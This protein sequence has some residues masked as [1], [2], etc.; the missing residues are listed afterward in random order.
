MPEWIGPSPKYRAF[1]TSQG[2]PALPRSEK[3]K[4]LT[5]YKQQPMYFQQQRGVCRA[6]CTFWLQTALAGQSNYLVD[7]LRTEGS[8]FKSFNQEGTAVKSY[9]IKAPAGDS[10]AAALLQEQLFAKSGGSRP[11][12]EQRAAMSWGK[13]APGTLYKCAPPVTGLDQM[14]MPKTI[15]QFGRAYY[16]TLATLAQDRTADAENPLYGGSYTHHA[17]ATVCLSQIFGLFDPNVGNFFVAPGDALELT[18]AY[19]ADVT[20]EKDSYKYKDNRLTV[21]HTAEGP[22]GG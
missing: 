18:T 20:D 14:S 22:G 5:I 9:L 16:G 3:L 13:I 19:W 1:A 11:S 4:A 17:I 6:H 10:A 2:G 7:L 15:V 8:G 21:E 12:D